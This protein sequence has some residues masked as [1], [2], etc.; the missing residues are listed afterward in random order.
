[1]IAER[2]EKL[3]SILRERGIDW[4]IITGNDPHGSEYPG[5]R[6]RTRAFISGFTGSA[7]VIAV[8]AER[9]ILWTD[10]RYYLQAEKELEGTGFE[11]MREGMEGVPTLYGFLSENSAEGIRIGV[12]STA[13]S[14]SEYRKL[15][16]ALSV[17]GAVIVGTGDLIDSLWENR[18]SVPSEAPIRIIDDKRAG[19]S[20]QSKLQRI[21]KIM[22]DRGARWTFISSLDD[23]AW[24]TNLRSSDIP[25]N[26]LFYSFLFISLSKAVLFIAPGRFDEETQGIVSRNFQIEDYGNVE[27]ILPSLIRGTGLYS[28]D[29]T[30]AMFID[31]VG[32][33]YH[34]T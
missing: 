5:Q 29:K 31:T 22:R 6:W 7:G 18:P 19:E 17:K 21:R 11:L 13:V 8:S 33:Q 1:M 32:A 15:Y 20:V 28:P 24:I 27:A 23:I 3:R 4:Y 14:I 2:L 10:S 26:P 16:E 9:A 25:Y 30:A 12:D 34:F